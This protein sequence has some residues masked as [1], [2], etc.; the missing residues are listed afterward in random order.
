MV[1]A[2]VSVYSYTPLLPSLVLLLLVLLLLLHAE[3]ARRGIFNRDFTTFLLLHN[4][5]ISKDIQ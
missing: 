4:E 1:T 5:I 2:V 3:R